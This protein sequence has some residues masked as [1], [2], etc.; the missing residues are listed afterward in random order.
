MDPF[1]YFYLC[2]VFVCH[3]VLSVPCSLVVTCWERLTS[4]LSCM[5]CFLSVFV[6]FPYGVLGQVWCLV[7]L[8]PDLCLPPLFNPLSS[9]NLTSAVGGTFKTTHT[10][11]SKL[12]K[13]SLS[14]FIGKIGLAMKIVK[15]Y[16]G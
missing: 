15:W 6:T 9:L 5:W 11:K 7:V 8:I 13:V 16:Q 10:Y 4:W 3:T 12:L 2:F 1:C 14:A